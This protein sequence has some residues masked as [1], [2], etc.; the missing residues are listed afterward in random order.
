MPHIEDYQHNYVHM[1]NDCGNLN[2]VEKSLN[3][4]IAKL[5]RGLS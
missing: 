1:N 2:F 5:D 3:V 4:N